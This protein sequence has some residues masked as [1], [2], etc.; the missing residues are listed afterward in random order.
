MATETLN[1]GIEPPI[2]AEANG[3][4]KEPLAIIRENSCLKGDNKQMNSEINTY[5]QNWI[6]NARKEY[7]KRLPSH[8]SRDSRN[9]V[10]FEVVSGR[11]LDVDVDRKHVAYTIVVTNDSKELDRN[12]NVIERRYTDFLDLYSKLRHTFPHHF[13]SF[14][15]PKKLFIRNF[16]P[17][18][19]TTRRLAFEELLNLIDQQQALKESGHFISFLQ[20]RELLEAKVWIESNR[21]DQAIPLVENTFR[22]LNKVHTDR[23]PAVLSCL[24]LLVACCDAYN[25]YCATYFAELALHRYEAV[26]DADLLQFYVP[27]LYVCLQRYQDSAAKVYVEERLISMKRR[28]INVAGHPSLLDIVMTAIFGSSPNK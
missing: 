22:L 14:N 6:S 17:E 15:F 12:P 18:S 4:F 5:I 3:S 27:L 2:L 11:I 10:K 28:G 1:N 23:H 19:I 13:T 9:L 20:N 7:E 8:R 21:F 26:S 25:Y 16:A 24:C